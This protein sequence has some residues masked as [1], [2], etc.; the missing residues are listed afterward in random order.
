[1]FRFAWDALVGPRLLARVA[2]AGGVEGADLAALRPTVAR[3]L[4]AAGGLPLVDEV[5]SDEALFE[6]GTRLLGEA[7]GHALA[8]AGS[9]PPQRAC[10][11]EASPVPALGGV[12]RARDRVP[13]NSA[14]A[15]A[16]TREA[17]LSPALADAVVAERRA[18]GAF[19]SLEDLERRVRGLGPHH[20][21]EVADRLDLGGPAE[22]LR[23]HAAP[24]GDLDR[25]LATLAALQRGATPAARLAAALETA[26][27][28]GAAEPHPATRDG[29][30]RAP[31][32]PA[33]DAWEALAWTGVLAGGAYV[34]SVPL[35][36]QGAA[37]SIDLCMYHVACGA[38]GHPTRTLLDGLV[39]AHGR[40]VQVRVLLDRDRRDDPYL[41]TVVN[42]EARRIL[43]KA[44][45]P[46][47]SDSPA[48]LLHSKFLILDGELAVL[49]SHN[50]SAGS[51]SG[52]DDVTL[53]LSSPGL[54][55]ALARR[56]E[57]LWSRA[58]RHPAKPAKAA[59]P[60]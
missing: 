35:L 41:S 6:L 28:L 13:L 10:L 47:R 37:R 2:A 5:P 56:F 12:V 44:G 29:R 23:A 32:A 36:I 54:A 25:D 20:L 39:A 16:L 40:G 17:G 45:V 26:A 50:W 27:A 8:A 38:A 46:V 7:V 52:Y 59:E 11:V 53:C 43:E 22:A 9:R 1:M 34:Q 58:G 57:E 31:P 48:R 55:G 51:Y 4:E 14:S 42:A 18:R 21:A 19:A 30:R 60:A 15:Q 3:C 24:T 49:G 33:G